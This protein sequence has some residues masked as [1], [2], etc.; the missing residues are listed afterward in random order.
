MTTECSEL[1]IGNVVGDKAAERG[2]TSLNSM[3]NRIQIE[4]NRPSSNVHPRTP[5]NVRWWKR[6]FYLSIAREISSMVKYY[7]ELV[8]YRRQPHDNG[9][10]FDLIDNSNKRYSEDS[11]IPAQSKSSKRS[12]ILIHGNF[13]FSFDIQGLL[14][15]LHDRVDSRSRLVVVAYNSYLRSI[16]RIATLLGIKSGKYDELT[17]ITRNDM[18]NLAKISGYQVVRYR[19]VVYC[20]FFLLGIGSLINYSLPIIPLLNRFAM[21]E[22]MVF[23]PLPRGAQ[24]RPS[25]SILIPARNE[26]G[27][28]QNAIDRLPDFN[29]RTE[30]IFVEGKSTDGTWEEI[31]RVVKEYNGSLI[32]KRFQQNGKGKGDAVRKGFAHATGELL[33]ILDADLTMPPE[34]LPRFYEAYVQGHGDFINGTR[35]MYPMEGQAMRSL[36]WIGNIFFAKALSYVLSMNIGDSLCGTKLFSKDDYQ[37]M[38]RW[39]SD[40]GDFDPFGDFEVLFP[41]AALGLGIVDIPVRYRDRTYGTTNISRFRHGTMLLKMVLVGLFRIKSGKW[42]TIS[43]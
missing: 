37:R 4:K 7:D 28:I 6:F 2:T 10:L 38:I 35:L 17:F 36:N 30:V 34:H 20:P 14:T 22:V 32:L 27:N 23:R 5:V 19:P 42:V 24:K 3:D 33:T 9:A 26:K 12:A 16:F 21:L 8:Q 40:F 11:D 39:R 43:G 31:D 18:E 25:L 29:T 13:N 41:A 1:S 15:S